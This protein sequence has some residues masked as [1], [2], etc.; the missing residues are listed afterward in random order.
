MTMDGVIQSPGGPQEDT[1]NNF[2]YGGWMGPYFDDEVGEHEMNTQMKQTAG[3][4]LGRKTYDIWSG[5]WP[6]HTD[7]WPQVNT[8]PKYVVSTTLQNPTWV[9]TTVLHDIDA[10]K[11]LKQSDGPDLQVYGSANLVQT[12]MKH[13]LIDEFWLKIFPIT[14]GMG[15]KLFENGTIPAS[16]TLID[17]KITPSGVIIASFKRD[18]NVKT[19]TVDAK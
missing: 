12:L 2:S 13:D 3:L 9:N 8:I 16:F 10:V 17:S 7:A 11:V 4:L 14:L 15:K 19:G 1:S 6:D 18:G 5:F